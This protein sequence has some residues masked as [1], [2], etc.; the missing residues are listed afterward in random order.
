MEYDS[1]YLLIIGNGFDRSL[2]LKTSYEDFFTSDHFKNLSRNNGLIRYLDNALNI[3]KWID[4]ETEIKNYSARINETKRLV[5]HPSFRDNTELEKKEFR[6]LIT[7]LHNYLDSIEYHIDPI[8]P[9]YKLI[10]SFI[11]EAG[12]KTILD[13]NYTKSVELIIQDNPAHALSHVKVHGSIET[14]NIIVGVEDEATE[15]DNFY[16]KAYPHYYPGIQVSKY[17]GEVFQEIIFFGY[18]LGQTDHSYFKEFFSSRSRR[19]SVN[20]P[21]ITIYFHDMKAA[22]ALNEELVKL[23]D[24]RLL[25]FKSLNNFVMKKASDIES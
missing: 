23:T 21:L 5:K 18:S 4:L 10:K 11:T 15:V 20:D 9:A 16:K 1:N 14:D 19:T 22:D 25:S 24:S 7:A 12:P 2:G 6:E 13:F 3:Q 8:S 17:L